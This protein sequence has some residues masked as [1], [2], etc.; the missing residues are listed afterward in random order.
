MLLLLVLLVDTKYLLRLISST[1]CHMTHEIMHTM[2]LTVSL[3]FKRHCYVSTL[4]ENQTTITFSIAPLALNRWDARLHP[5]NAW[6]GAY[7]PLNTQDAAFQSQ[8][9]IDIN[10][11]LALNSWAYRWVITD[12]NTAVPNNRQD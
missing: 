5:L 4:K 9:V 10:I 7:H 11:S 8:L 3:I 12:Y 2:R 6:D 1:L